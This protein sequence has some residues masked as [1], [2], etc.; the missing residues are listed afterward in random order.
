MSSIH[1]PFYQPTLSSRLK[2]VF[3]GRNGE[4]STIDLE[5]KAGRFFDSLCSPGMKGLNVEQGKVNIEY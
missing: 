1:R 2:G 3:L 4:I 5:A